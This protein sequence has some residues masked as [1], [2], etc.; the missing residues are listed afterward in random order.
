MICIGQF[1][2]GIKTRSLLSS[3][4]SVCSIAK[5]KPRLG[6]Q[7]WVSTWL[8]F[9]SSITSTSKKKSLVLRNFVSHLCTPHVTLGQS[10]VFQDG[11]FVALKPVRPLVDHALDLPASA[12]QVLVLKACAN[13]NRP[14][15]FFK[16]NIP[17]VLHDLPE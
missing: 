12:F 4:F 16:I 8:A 2:R 5:A 15:A 13:T 11:F 10:F 3:S 7:L 9:I 1:S 6:I 14:H 17:H